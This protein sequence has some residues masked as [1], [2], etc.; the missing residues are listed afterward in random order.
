MF[1]FYIDV[2]EWFL[3]CKIVVQTAWKVEK[4]GI[5]AGTNLVSVSYAESTIF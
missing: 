4:D 5:E 3:L 1:E 2:N